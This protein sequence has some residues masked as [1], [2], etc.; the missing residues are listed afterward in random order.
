MNKFCQ[1]CGMPLISKGTDQR[2]TEKDGTLSNNYCHLCYQDGAFT[3]PAIT[4]EEMLARGKNGIATS[5]SNGLAKFFLTRF[6]PYQLKGL[7]RW[8]K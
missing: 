3:E 8:K 6:Y 1:S 2:G 5:D 4:Y 7:S